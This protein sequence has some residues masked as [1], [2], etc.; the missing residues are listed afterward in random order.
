MKNFWQANYPMVRQRLIDEDHGV[1]SDEKPASREV[2][3]ESAIRKRIYYAGYI[4]KLKPRY[5]A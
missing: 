2:A 4:Q 3:V 5:C 1:L